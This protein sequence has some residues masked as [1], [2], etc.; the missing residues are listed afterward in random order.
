MWRAFVVFIAGIG[1][2]IALVGLNMDWQIHDVVLTIPLTTV[3]LGVLLCVVAM[4]TMMVR[5]A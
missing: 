4:M 1:T 5:Y 2:G 3:I